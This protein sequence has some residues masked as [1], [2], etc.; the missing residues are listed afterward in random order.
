[1][2]D[3]RGIYLGIFSTP[4]SVEEQLSGEDKGHAGN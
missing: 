4:F 1:M 2:L 3:A